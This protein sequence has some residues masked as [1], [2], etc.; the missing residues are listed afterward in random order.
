MR[1][2]EQDIPSGTD[3]QVGVTTSLYKNGVLVDTP[4]NSI[5]NFDW[6]GKRFFATSSIPAPALYQVIRT[7]HAGDTL[8]LAAGTITQVSNGVYKT[9]ITYANTDADTTVYNWS[10]GYVQYANST[11]E[12]YKVAAGT[13][14]VNWTGG[15][16][17]IQEFV[18]TVTGSGFTAAGLEAL[19]YRIFAGT[20]AGQSMSNVATYNYVTYVDTIVGATYAAVSATVHTLSFR[21]NYDH[22]AN[23]L[24]L[25]TNDW[26]AS[27]YLKT[28]RDYQLKV[29]KPSVLEVIK[30][31]LSQT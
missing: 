12:T 5:T 26:G 6:F 7:N 27:G 25:W 20:T 10:G 21:P 30:I 3:I 11:N 24:Q 4:H 28:F 18:F 8:F 13:W 22:L 17:L 19:A 2:S 29:Y 1:L 31:T 16:T 23:S 15:D 9:S 14:S